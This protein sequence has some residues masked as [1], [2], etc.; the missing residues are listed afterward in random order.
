[1]IAR[2]LPLPRLRSERGD[3]Y[4]LWPIRFGLVPVFAGKRCYAFTWHGWHIRYEKVPPAK[5]SRGCMPGNRGVYGQ[6]LHLGFFQVRLGDPQPRLS[7]E[8]TGHALS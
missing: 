8:T 3:R 4:L 6:T 7:A 5:T 1:M 2:R